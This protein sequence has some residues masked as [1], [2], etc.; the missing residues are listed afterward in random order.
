MRNKAFGING[1]R[2][3]VRS[4]QFC[5]GPLQNWI[6]N[7]HPYIGNIGTFLTPGMKPTGVLL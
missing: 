4:R 7:T 3:I 6:L 1:K 5:N 2:G